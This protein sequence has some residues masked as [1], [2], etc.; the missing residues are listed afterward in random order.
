M[1]CESSHFRRRFAIS[2]LLFCSAGRPLVP[3][4]LVLVVPSMSF[5]DSFKACSNPGH[6][7]TCWQ[8]PSQDRVVVVSIKCNNKIQNLAGVRCC[9]ETL[10]RH[11]CAITVPG[12]AGRWHCDNSQTKKIICAL[13]KTKKSIV[14][15]TAIFSNRSEHTLRHFG[16]P[17]RRWRHNVFGRP[18]DINDKQTKNKGLTLRTSN[19]IVFPALSRAHCTTNDHTQRGYDSRR[20]VHDIE[21]PIFADWV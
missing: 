6:A 5:S 2:S 11:Y 8:W 16:C 18:W 17:P 7:S 4:F 9:I 10:L 12:C 19:D 15:S 3:K 20:Y 13:P 14:T 1:P 21:P